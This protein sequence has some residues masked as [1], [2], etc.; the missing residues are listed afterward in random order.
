MEP[1]SWPIGRAS[2]VRKDMH[3]KYVKDFFFGFVFNGL[4]NNKVGFADL[5]LYQTKLVTF[6]VIRYNSV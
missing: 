1:S 3:K 4:S 5:C 2:G 6:I